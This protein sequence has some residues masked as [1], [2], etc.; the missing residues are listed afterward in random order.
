MHGCIQARKR[1]I[2]AGMHVYIKVV[3]HAYASMS[4][5]VQYAGEYVH[6][7]MRIPESVYE[8]VCM[9]SCLCIPACMRMHVCVC[10]YACMHVCMYAC[11]RD[12]P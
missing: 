1:R 9:Y 11:L 4:M 7:H 2:P 6:M 5:H 10:M 3:V 8:C 12:P